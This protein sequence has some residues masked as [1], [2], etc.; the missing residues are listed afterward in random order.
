MST[1]IGFIVYVRS[2]PEA[3]TDFLMNRIEATFS[4]DVTDQ[5]KADLRAAYAAYREKLRAKSV[6]GRSLD[7]VRVVLM[8]GGGGSTIGRDQVHELTAAF[9]EAA[10]RRDQGV[11][12]VVITPP[13]APFSSGTPAPLASPTP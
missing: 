2:H 8:R 12:A 3:F 5:D 11:P 1:V 4:S 6:D 7:R 10:G 9:R 13:D